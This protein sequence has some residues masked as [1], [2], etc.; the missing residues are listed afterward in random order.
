[1]NSEIRGMI[2][3][4]F[5][6]LSL[7]QAKYKL[8]EDAALAILREVAEDLRIAEILDRAWTQ[9]QHYLQAMSSRQG[10]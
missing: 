3:E 7:I 2:E 9:G 5:R 8:G 1:M 6:M 10:G 4:Y